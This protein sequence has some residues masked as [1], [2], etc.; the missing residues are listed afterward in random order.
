MISNP[1]QPLRIALAEDDADYRKAL[2]ALLVALGHEVACQAS[3]GKELLNEC[4]REP[5]DLAIA[6][7]DM[8]VVD[9]LEAAEALS[10]RGV[11]VILLSGHPDVHRVNL[12]QEPVAARLLKPVSL[13]RLQDAIAKALTWRKAPG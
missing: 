8:P 10:Q 3:N 1:A 2:T 9:G 7:L 5:V 13:A 6:D 12:D 11:P 4:S